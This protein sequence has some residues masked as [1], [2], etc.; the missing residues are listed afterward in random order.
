MRVKLSSM[1][2]PK[3]ISSVAFSSFSGG[4]NLRDDPTE[5][6]SSQSPDMLNMWYRDGVLRKRGGQK[7]VIPASVDSRAGG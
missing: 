3:D 6:R 5:V 7:Q 1:P 2:D 4:L